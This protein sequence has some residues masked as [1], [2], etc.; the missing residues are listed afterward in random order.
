M[1]RKRNKMSTKNKSIYYLNDEYKRKRTECIEY[2]TSTSQIIEIP[3]YQFNKFSDIYEEDLNLQEITTKIKSKVNELSQQEWTSDKS[4]EKFFL[5]LCEEKV[6]ITSENYW[7]LH[8]LSEIFQVSSLHQ[9]LS[10]YAL[11]HKEDVD[12]IITLIE[13]REKERKKSYETDVEFK[14]EDE[15]SLEIED[16]L[17]HKIK[18][19]LNNERFGRLPICV[20]YRIIEKN[21]KEDIPH[22]MLYEFINKSIK[23]RYILYTFLNISKLNDAH[24]KFLYEN[25]KNREVTKTSHYYNYLKNEIE[26]VNYLKENQLNLENRIRMLEKDNNMKQ[27]QIKEMKI[28]NE[29]LIKEK[30]QLEEDNKKKQLQIKEL[31]ENNPF[32]LK[33]LKNQPNENT[34]YYI[35]SQENIQLCLDVENGGKN[36]NDSIIVSKFQNTQSQKWRVNGNEIINVN[37]GLAMDICGGEILDSQIIQHG[38]HGGSN[39]QWT[40]ADGTIKSPRG[41]CIEMKSCTYIVSALFSNKINQKWKFFYQ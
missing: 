23:E 8:R 22:D 35:M 40:L 14:Y 37:S 30:Q 36:Y 34:D 18:V 19:V 39:Q 33:E 10:K 26:Y 41:Y 6:E 4:I 32:Q 5:L 21:N 3:L 17:K 7:D 27:Q 29:K 38:R 24:F 15:Y 25:Y 12:F 13:G 2:Q 16:L 20:I 28:L 11:D 31:N 1:I 9:L